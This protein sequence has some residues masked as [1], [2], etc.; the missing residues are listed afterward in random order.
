MSTLTEPLPSPQH[1]S[2]AA[3]SICTAKAVRSYF[4]EGVLPEDGTR[5]EPEL[6]PFGIRAGEKENIDERQLITASRELS[7]KAAWGLPTG[8]LAF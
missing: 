2:L 7:A 1:T 3:P 6:L 8:E 5:C 4:Q